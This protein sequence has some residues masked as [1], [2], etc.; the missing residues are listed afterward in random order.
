MFG[1]L[2]KL[3]N[4][5]LNNSE[6]GPNNLAQDVITLLLFNYLDKEEN[7]MTDILPVSTGMGFGNNG[8]LSDAAGAFAGALFGSW[9]GDGWGGNGWGRGF[10]GAAAEATGFST[11]ILNDGI[12]A[13]QNSINGMNMSLSNGLCNLGYQNLDQSN[14]TN[15]AML[16]GF[17]SL[18]H[19]NCQNTSNIVSAVNGLGTQMQNCCCATQ[20]LIEQQGCQTRELIQALNTQ[21]IRDKLC[22]AKAKNAALESNLFTNNAISGAVNTIITHIKAMQPTTTTAA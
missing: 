21:D 17:A 9:F 3:S 14:K 10:P 6:Y 5:S 11:Q 13:I 20:R 4:V 18:G 7:T 16:Q 1:L 8:G 12:N 15:V 19:D 2:R 22:D